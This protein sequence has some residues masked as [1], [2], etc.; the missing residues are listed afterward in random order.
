MSTQKVKISVL[1]SVFDTDFLLIKR[2]IESVLNQDFRDFE[3]ILIDDGSHNDNKNELFNFVK[4]HEAVIRYFRHS[5]VGQS[6]SINRGVLNSQ[7]EYIAILD[8]DDEYK[9]NYLSSCLHALMDGDLIASTPQTIVNSDQDYFVPDRKNQN[10]LI[11]VDDCILFATLFGKR[12]VFADI[13]FKGGYAADAQFFELASQK[14]EAKK[15]D[16]RTYVY[17]RNNPNSVV[18]KMKIKYNLLNV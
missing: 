11:H 16:L 18:S 9:P 5:N 2:A 12:I 1:I 4:E 10:E 3:I 8:G 15:V 13:K 7:A 14:Y 6:E 17:Y